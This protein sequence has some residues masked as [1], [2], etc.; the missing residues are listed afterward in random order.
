MT[1]QQGGAPGQP[2]SNSPQDQESTQV[3]MPVPPAAP[4]YA[5][6]P[7][8]QPPPQQPPAYGQGPS[9][10]PS[11]PPGYGGQPPTYGGPPP[12]GYPPTG[13]GYQTPPPKKGGPSLLVIGA[14]ALALVLVLGIGGMYALGLGPFAPSATPTAAAQPTP[15]PK[16]TKTPATASATPSEVAASPT[17]STAPET[18]APATTAPATTAPAT[19]APATATASAPI[20]FPPLTLPP[21]S[22]PPISPGPSPSMTANDTALLAHVPED[23][24]DSCTPSVAVTPAMS[25]LNCNTGFERGI[26]MSYTQYPDVTSMN[27]AYQFYVNAYGEGAGSDLCSNADNWPSEIGYT[28]D[29]EEAG[30]V[31]CSEFGTLPAM[32]WTDENLNILTWMFGIGE[33]TRDDMY[34]FWSNEAGPF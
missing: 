7:P 1:G 23:F 3:G 12:G 32:F 11:P 31:L 34:D 13:Y 8:Q 15:T 30:R 29:N 9:Y 5:Q 33:V 14:I 21:L 24:R 19:T 6:Q 27:A 18:T 25:S 2:G 20:S 22:F 28:I 17:E 10:A 26:Y 16:P 4:A